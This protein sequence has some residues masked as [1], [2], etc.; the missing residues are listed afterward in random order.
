MRD[1]VMRAT[2]APRGV[3]VAGGGASVATSD[4]LRPQEWHEV[5]APPPELASAAGAIAGGFG[6]GALAP[7]ELRRLVEELAARTDL[8]QPLVISDRRRRRYRLLFEDPRLDVWVLSWMPGQKTGFH[9]HGASNVALTALQGT[10]LEQQMRLGAPSLERE[11][12]PGRLQ[13]GPAGY[14]HSVAHARGEPAVTLH[15][16]SPPLV[17]VGQYR[18][19]SAGELLRERQHGR[20]ELLDNTLGA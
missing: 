18:A 15:A 7:G 4:A 20:Q 9:D 2:A 16:Y 13:Q 5:T 6:A 10:V 17:D 1:P 3:M 8:W 12:V 11:L 14:I 19:G